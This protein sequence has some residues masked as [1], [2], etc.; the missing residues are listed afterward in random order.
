MRRRIGYRLL[1]VFVRREDHEVNHK[2]LFRI[3]CEEQLHVRRRGGRKRAIGTRAPMTLSLMTSQRWS[4][5]FVSDQLTDCRRF[6]VMTAV[7]DTTRECLTLIAEISLSGARVA[8][9]LATLFDT[10]GKP[11]TVVSDRR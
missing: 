4:L 10:C 7:N 2:R 1:H 3:Y 8:R 9:E 5:D 6:R 11:V